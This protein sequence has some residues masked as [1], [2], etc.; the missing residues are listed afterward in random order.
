MIAAF[1]EIGGVVTLLTIVIV[2]SL[3]KGVQKICWAHSINLIA[4]PSLDS[5]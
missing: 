4:P 5:C 2:I 1:F 3:F